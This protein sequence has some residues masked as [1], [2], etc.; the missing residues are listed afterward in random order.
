M[1]VTGY[2]C[3]SRR[4]TEWTRTL[5]EI[6][7]NPAHRDRLGAAARE[8]ALARHTWAAAARAVLA[9]LELAAESPGTAVPGVSRG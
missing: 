7:T 9:G 2:L 3:L 6:W 5:G 1:P 4:P 8:W